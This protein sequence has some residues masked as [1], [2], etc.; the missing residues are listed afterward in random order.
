MKKGYKTFLGIVVALAMMLTMM[1]VVAAPAFADSP[2]PPAGNCGTKS[3]SGFADNAT[4][5]YGSGTLT[6]SGTGE[7]GPRAFA[8]YDGKANINTITIGSGITSISANA[9]EGL[10][11]VSSVAL[12]SGLKSIGFQA[13]YNCFALDEITFPD[14]LE[15]IDS[16]AFYNDGISMIDIPASM[17]SLNWD[18]FGAEPGYGDIK[19][20]IMRSSDVTFVEPVINP[21]KIP[22]SISSAGPIGG[23]YDY[24]FAWTEKVPDHAFSYLKNRDFYSLSSVV[25]PD[26][27]TEIGASAFSGEDK[28]TAVAFPNGIK[29]IKEYAFYGTGLTD[30][31]LPVSA[32]EIG[33]EA[34]NNC[35]DLEKVT[36]LNPKCGIYDVYED[37]K[38]L[39][40]AV[41]IAGYDGSTAQAFANK[42]SRTFESLGDTPS[43]VGLT[44]RIGSG[45]GKLLINGSDYGN[46]FEGTYYVGSSV[47][48]K[49]VP[50]NGY[51]L[52]NW[53]IGNTIGTS[54][55]FTIDL[56]EE[57]E[58]VVWLK[59]VDPK[60]I[61][62]ID[63]GNIRKDLDPES[64]VVFI[65]EVHDEFD[66]DGIKFTDK[67]E[68]YDMAWTSDD[69]IISK[70]EGS[71]K[72]LAGRTYNYSVVLKAKPGW[73]FS[74]DF[75][76]I[77]GGREVSEYQKEIGDDGK[78]IIL[79]GFEEPVIIES[80]S[81][82]KPAVKP[83]AP[84][85]IQ[86][87]PAVK[88]AKPKAAKKKATVKWKKVSKK[89]QKKIQGIE[90]RVVGP[91]CNKTFTAGKKKTSKKVGG[92]VSKQ[93]Y[94]VS[95][96]AYK[97][98][99]KVKHVSAWKSKTVKIK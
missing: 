76:F 3:D 46:Q 99:G 30:V 37:G 89:N 68:I 27:I 18:A 82:P 22:N 28:L 96:R 72:P 90:I 55:E 97:W 47:N 32:N 64:E 93:K 31:T 12:P 11:G 24:Q 1:P 38:A 65:T 4:F 84:A 53:A 57:T 95:V 66:S 54:S 51:T 75:T 13:F 35:S 91:G 44:V 69:H 42:Y 60:P 36:I 92:L 98:V 33:R 80:R 14:T 10:T 20:V 29:K 50:G 8:D 49:I 78:G 77:Y 63:I 25:L 62:T 40:S 21:V 34:F 79:S 59:E 23:D 56:D 81:E 41:T 6:I 58:C 83:S 45:E 87:L 48:V 19:K 74:D 85:E 7:I 17:K 67:M 43:T 16:Q 9:F 70:N 5:T 73:I 61:T 2:I 15:S 88:I 39:G 71:G 26:T 52:Q 86:D 94:T